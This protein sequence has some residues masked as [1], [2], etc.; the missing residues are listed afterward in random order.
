M[1]PLFQVS[2]TFSHFTAASS[3]YQ[4]LSSCLNFLKDFLL[5][6]VLINESLSCLQSRAL[7]PVRDTA[8]GL[9]S[10]SESGL[11]VRLWKPDNPLMESS[12]AYCCLYPPPS[13][14]HTLY[15]DLLKK[16]AEQQEPALTW[17]ATMATGKEAGRTEAGGR[18]TGGWWELLWPACGGH[19]AQ[20][21]LAV[22]IW[23]LR[24]TNNDEA[25]FVACPAL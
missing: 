8:L 7:F 20:V 25:A 5:L 3:D 15:E 9:C 14:T 16:R 12:S 19:N 24:R 17:Q 4:L 21:E 18:R 1:T 10:M 22:I 6:L 13:L 11:S 2:S 23:L